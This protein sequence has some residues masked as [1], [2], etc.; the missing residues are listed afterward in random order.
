MPGQLRTFGLLAAVA[1]SVVVSQVG[2]SRPVLGWS[3]YPSAFPVDEL[4]LQDATAHDVVSTHL[5]ATCT[6]PGPILFFVK[7]QV[8]DFPL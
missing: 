7:D 8:R 4:F 5:R 1:L 6:A 2:A 3:S